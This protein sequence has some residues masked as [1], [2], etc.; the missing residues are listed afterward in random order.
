MAEL[1]TLT[2]CDNSQAKPNVSGMIYRVLIAVMVKCVRYY[3][4][5][6]GL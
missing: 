1:H 2:A 3:V 5:Q 4:Q 6:E